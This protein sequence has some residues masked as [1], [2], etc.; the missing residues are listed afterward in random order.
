MG[1]H[2]D[3]GVIVDVW[4]SLAEKLQFDVQFVYVPY[5]GSSATTTI[6]QSVSPFIDTF[7]G[8]MN[9]DSPPRR[10]AG[11]GMVFPYYADDQMKLFTTTTTQKGSRIWSFVVPFSGPM[12]GMLAAVLF[13]NAIFI[14]LYQSPTGAQPFFIIL[15]YSLN[16]FAGEKLEDKESVAAMVITTAF[17]LVVLVLAAAYTANLAAVLI[18]NTVTTQTPYSTFAEANAQGATVCIG[19]GGAQTI[20]IPLLWP[21]IKWITNLGSPA[22]IQAVSTG[23]CSGAVTGAMTGQA[24]L[25]ESLVNPKCNMASTGDQSIYYGYTLAYKYDP[26]APYCSGFLGDLLS[27][28]V[29]QLKQSGALKQIIEKNVAD[30]NDLNCPVTA[31]VSLS[32]EPEQLAGVWI[33]YGFMML[34]A[35]VFHYVKV[36]LCKPYVIPA[37]AGDPAKTSGRDLYPA[38]VRRLGGGSGGDGGGGGAGSTSTPARDAAPE[39]RPPAAPAAMDYDFLAAEG[40]G[41]YERPARARK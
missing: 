26:L 11:L 35:V 17:S 28:G 34:I 4:K 6:L 10:T 25:G 29:T 16:S 39:V 14:W 8:L 3:G 41:G 22:F 27:R 19:A 2:F 13:V 36:C 18:A 12:W 23:Q 21:G 37:L 30:V 7:A 40:Y 33:V 9:Y 31:P 15:F 38:V 20:A 24:Y 5:A 1:S 32:L